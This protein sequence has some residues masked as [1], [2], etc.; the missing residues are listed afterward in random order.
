MSVQEALGL[1]APAFRQIEPANLKFIEAIVATYIEKEE[2]QVRLVAVQYAGEVFSHDNV[3]SRYTLLLGAGDIKDD[4]ARASQAAL[5]SGLKKANNPDGQKRK[6][7][8]VEL[9]P[10]LPDF[11]EMLMI[12]IDKSNIRAKSSFKVVVGEVSL[13]FSVS[14]GSQVCDYLRLCLWQSAGVL[15]SQDMLADP[16]H[17]APRVSRYLE[18]LGKK[19]DLVVKFVELAEKL[20][21]ASAGMSQAQALLQLIA[22]GPPEIRTRFEKRMDWFKFLLNNTREDLRETIATI[23]SLVGATISRPDFEKS[24]RDLSRSMKEKQLEFQH[25]AILALGYSFGRRCLL[26]RMTGGLT[27]WSLYTETVRLILGQLDHPNTLI[28]SA[29]CLALAELARCGPLPLPD[30]AKDQ[31]QD[32]KEDTKLSLIQRLLGLV[33]SGKTN[34]RVRERAALAAGSLCLGDRNFPHRRTLLE[35]FIELAADI[36]DIELHFSIGEALVFISLGVKS[37]A[38]RDLWSVEEGEFSPLET[39]QQE[40]E[41]E[42]EEDNVELAWLLSQLT[43]KLTRSTH[44]S[45]KQASCLW[46]LAVVKHCMA[47]SQV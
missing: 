46:L 42:K 5:Y 41:E 24:V 33:K 43:G 36:K 22:T 12:V 7:T 4:V 9:G 34:M 8:A 6:K 11:L 35:S 27:D 32:Q 44:P 28:L 31:D 2:K 15:P 3:A 26:A 20:L 13:P 21:R 16:R 45:V 14:V 10:V 37:P 38:A 25:G 19:K 40:K 1:M 47:Q 39:D 29:A 30:Q 23:Y 18:T 17:E